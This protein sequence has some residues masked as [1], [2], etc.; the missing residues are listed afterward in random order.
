MVVWNRDVGS[1][2]IVSRVPMGW[3]NDASCCRE[4]KREFFATRPLGDGSNELELVGPVPL[5][6]VR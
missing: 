6:P 4:S 5:G 2:P 1:R 3:F